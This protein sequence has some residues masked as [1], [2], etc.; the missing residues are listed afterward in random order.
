MYDSNS[1]LLKVYVKE[2]TITSS[3]LFLPFAARQLLTMATMLSYD[4]EGCLCSS[5]LA[6]SA[7]D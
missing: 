4:V 1:A 2:R 5:S 3:R 7:H 6:D